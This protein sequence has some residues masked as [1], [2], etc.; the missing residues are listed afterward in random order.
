MAASADHDLPAGLRYMVEHGHA[1]DGSH[2]LNTEPTQHLVNPRAVNPTQH[3]AVAE[4]V[5]RRVQADEQ[6]RS[7]KEAS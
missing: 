6:M 4:W 1:A 5:R 3:A 7:A 2:A